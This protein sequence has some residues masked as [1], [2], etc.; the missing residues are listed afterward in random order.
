MAEV[1]ERPDLAPDITRKYRVGDVRHCFA[2][3]ALAREILG[4][5]PRV[6]IVDGLTE[7]ARWL[8]DQVAADRPHE[9]PAEIV[10]RGLSL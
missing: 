9:T 8:E 5:A 4:Y 6:G 7:L 2:D 3:I 1:L 10:A